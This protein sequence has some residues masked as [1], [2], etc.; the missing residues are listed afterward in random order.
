MIFLGACKDRLRK[1]RRS[2]QSPCGSLLIDGR[3][4]LGSVPS[5]EVHT[6]C[7][8]L[9]PVRAQALQS[10]TQWGKPHI[11]SEASFYLGIGRTPKQVGKGTRKAQPQMSGSVKH[12]TVKR[13]SVMGRGIGV[14]MLLDCSRLSLQTSL[15]PRPSYFRC[16]DYLLK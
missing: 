7:V 9:L 2:Y 12:E 11:C 8:V 13:C 1:L 15:L 10:R 3:A 5:L 14:I 6:G 16:Q 4:G